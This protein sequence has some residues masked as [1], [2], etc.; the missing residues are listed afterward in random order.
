[1]EKVEYKGW[2][3]CY[4]LA[5]DKVELIVTTD[6]GPRIIRFAPAGGENILKEYEA[7]LG[8]TGGDEWNIFGGHRLWH[9]PEAKPRTYY[10]DNGPVEIKAYDGFVRVTQPTEPT[11]G[12][13]KEIDIA[14]S[15]GA[16]HVKLTHRLHNTSLWAVTLAP[17][18]L[19]VM[20]QGGTA[21]VPIPPR[22]SHEDHL[23]PTNM[24]TLWAYTNMADP[25]W[26]WGE[27]YIL[28]RQDPNA[29]GPQ[30][31]GAM[32][33]DGWA[34]YVRSS[35]L[36]VKTFT[37]TPGLEYPDFG[38]SVETFTN[39]DMLELETVGPFVCLEP[40]AA[41]EHV[42]DWYLFG[43]VPTPANDADVNAHVLPKVKTIK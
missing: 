16:A 37:F 8:V 23:L 6:V 13:Q 14:L 5:N 26:T 24:L 1:M 31:I 40:G 39:A 30:K 28:L 35:S 36:F 25:R 33:P 43:G 32:V 34:A 2:P 27:Q 38:C 21:I 41:V 17:W 7:T 22:G 4:K 9:A 3:N 19:S 11:T 15:P 10:P 42:E 29:A 18:A 20:A 12:I